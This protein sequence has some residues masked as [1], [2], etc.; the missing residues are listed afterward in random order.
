MATLW[1]SEYDHLAVAVN[2][3]M[4]G[5]EPSLTTQKIDFTTATSSAKFNRKTRFVRLYASTD[6]R[7]AFGPG[8]VATGNSMP[9]TAKVGE[10]F[11]VR[12]EDR[13][14]CYDGVS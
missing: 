7:V 6:C 11:G 9:I 1:I 12:P 8:R 3:V 5:K 10:F 4:C 14:S 2:G 13:V